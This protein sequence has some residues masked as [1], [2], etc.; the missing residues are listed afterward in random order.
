MKRALLYLLLLVVLNLLGDFIIHF[1]FDTYNEMSDYT[2][3]IIVM[4]ISTLYYCTTIPRIKF[5]RLF[6]IPIIYLSISSF[7]IFLGLIGKEYEYESTNELL[8]I[9]TSWICS[10]FE[11]IIFIIGKINNEI[12]R[13]CLFYIFNS[14]GVSLILFGVAA[15]TDYLN[16]KLKWD[17]KRL[18]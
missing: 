15:F 4:V 14:I 8:Y 1:C 12:L 6:L 5:L 17:I 13:K 16:K 7:L 9:G 2:N 18:K 3:Y 11:S 10:L